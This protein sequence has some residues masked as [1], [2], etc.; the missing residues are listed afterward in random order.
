M[1]RVYE[2]TLEPGATDELRPRLD[3]AVYVIDGT[4]LRIV[5]EDRDGAVRTRTEEFAS[6]TGQWMPGGCR[7]QLVNTGST[8]YR[9]LSV[10]LK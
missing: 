8:T 3:T 7:R 6:T 5:E 1:Y 2:T 10:E 4:A 9:D